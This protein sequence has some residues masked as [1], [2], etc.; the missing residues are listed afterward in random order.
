M[1]LVRAHLKDSIKL[2][3]DKQYENL[4]VTVSKSK[5]GI[6]LYLIITMSLKQIVLIKL[7]A[8]LAH[9]NEL[10]YRQYCEHRDE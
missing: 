5:H 9:Y 1:M 2:M 3:A 8:M 4:E 10:V 7:I 6:P